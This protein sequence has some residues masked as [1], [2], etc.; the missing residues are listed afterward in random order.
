MRRTGLQMLSLFGRAVM[1]ALVMFAGLVAARAQSPF[2]DAPASLADGPPGSLVRQEPMDGAPLG[3]SSYRVLYRSTGLKGEPILVSGVVI[4]P[5]GPPPP[6]GRPIV[7][8][9]HPTSGIVPRCA[10][11]LAIFLFQQIQGLRSM[12]ARGYI[13][14]ATDYPGLGTP[15]PHPYLV[16]ESEGRAVLDIVRVERDLPG[17]G[18][19]K[20]FTLWGH[21]QGGQAVLFAGQLAP[22]YAPDLHLLGVAAAAP[23]TDLATLMSDDINSVGGK[24]ITAMTLWSWHRVYGAALDGVLDPRALP[25][26]DR[27]AREC[28]EGPF[29]IFIR[30]RTERPLQKYF[31]TVPDPTKRE[32]WR[33]LL[34]KNSAGTLPAGMPVFLAQGTV[35][36]IIRPAVTRAYMGRLCKAG[37]PVKMVTLPNIGHGRAAQASTMAAVNW[38]TDRFAGKPAPNDCGG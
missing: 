15:G 3:A 31:L 36:Q 35:D 2:Y 6:G 10:P 32:P 9:A 27:L 34:E 7:A 17:A 21:S 13:V 37:S 1:A 26:I 23:A 19:T 16:G 38:M 14:A 8:W 18:G 20:D 11:S 30:Q 4:V 29:D 33:S 12:V 28:I 24:N 25:V 22:T 5:Q